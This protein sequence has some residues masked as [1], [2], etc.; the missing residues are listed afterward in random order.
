MKLN[1]GERLPWTDDRIEKLK[2]LWSSGLS[3]GQIAKQLGGVTRNAVIGKAS[4]LGLPGR[5]RPSSP[6]GSA[7]KPIRTSVR[8]LPTPK[9]PR[10]PK[11]N[12]PK[13]NAFVVPP[14]SGRPTNGAMS[15]LENAEARAAYVEP[16]TADVGIRTVLTIRVFGECRWPVGDPRADDFAFCGAPCG[17]DESY[18]AAHAERAY[19]K[20][21]P[22]KPKKS[23]SELI[24]SV[25]R[26][27]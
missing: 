13:A 7:P 23:A 6:A 11:N 24:R 26:Y 18:C 5:G 12:L 20:P 9:P 16:P 19:V 27:V 21:A 25:R 17:I 2:V 14:I 1:D 22:G 15:A 4:R 3:A 8:S 10:A